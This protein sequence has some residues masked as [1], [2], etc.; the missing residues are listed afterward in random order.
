MKHVKDE[1]DGAAEEGENATNIFLELARVKP[2]GTGSGIGVAIF[3]TNSTGQ[4]AF[5]DNKLAVIQHEFSPDPKGDVARLW[6]LKGGTLPFENNGG[7][8]TPP[9]MGSLA[10][11]PSISEDDDEEER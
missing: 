2:D 3:S 10:K 1:G 5:L 8:S 4:L 7:G 9:T 6:K 11:T